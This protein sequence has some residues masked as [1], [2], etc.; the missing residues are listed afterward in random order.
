MGKTDAEYLIPEVIGNEAITLL[1]ARLFLAQFVRRDVSGT[2]ASVGDTINIPKYGAFVVRDK[3]Q[4]E[5]V[6]TQKANVDR[7][8]IVLNKHKEITFGI[9]DYLRAVKT[10]S[11]GVMEQSLMGQAMTQLAEQI[12]KDLAALSVGLTINAA[13]DATTGITEDHILLA[14]KRLTDNRASLSDRMLLVDT[15]SGN[16]IM[17]IDR[18][19]DASKYGSAMIPNGELGRIHG[20]TAGESILLRGSGSPTTYDSLAIHRDAL[21]LVTR[22]FAKSIVPSAQA[23]IGQVFDEQ[24]GITLRVELFRDSKAKADVISIDVLY[25]CGVVRAELG[26]VIST[27]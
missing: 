19:T 1:R 22:P 3:S 15:G 8:P 2:P 9:E 12:E 21:A 6:E 13:I 14:K 25:G 10:D 5:D 7:V 24:S 11:P 20:F 18:F 16:K 23:N 17:K 4:N 26:Q 27:R